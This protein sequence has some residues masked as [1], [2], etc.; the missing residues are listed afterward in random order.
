MV[1]E[2]FILTIFALFT[3]SIEEITEFIGKIFKYVYNP[4]FDYSCSHGNRVSEYIVDKADYHRNDEYINLFYFL[5]LT[6]MYFI[7][8]KYTRRYVK[9]VE[10]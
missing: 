7:H 5:I 2:D 8:Y 1:T 6:A 4:V 10:A 3:F 9:Q